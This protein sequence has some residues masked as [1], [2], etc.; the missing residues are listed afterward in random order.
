MGGGKL[1]H[2]A[3]SEHGCNRAFVR[4]VRVAQNPPSLKEYL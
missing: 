3:D 4:A 2:P 1:I